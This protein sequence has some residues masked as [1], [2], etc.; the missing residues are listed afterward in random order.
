YYI[1]TLIACFAGVIFVACGGG[2]DGSDGGNALAPAFGGDFAGVIID[3]NPRIT[4]IENNGFVYTST[5][6]D[7]NFPQS[8]QDIGGQFW[9]VPSANY[10]TAE[11]ILDFTSVTPDI[12]DVIMSL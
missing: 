9:Y 6:S 1:S 7:N 8:G 12:P 10:E 11:M 3:I 5:G 2:G 4:F